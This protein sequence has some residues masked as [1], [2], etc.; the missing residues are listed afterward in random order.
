[1]KLAILRVEEEQT[2]ANQGQHVL[3]YRDIKPEISNW[4]LPNNLQPVRKYVDSV[5][6]H[7]NDSLGV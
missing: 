5:I 6:L 2:G 4:I 3:H 1:M 7:P